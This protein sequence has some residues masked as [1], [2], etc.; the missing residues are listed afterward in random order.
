[1][2]MGTRRIAALREAA[3]AKHRL[4]KHDGAKWG[5]PDLVGE[6]DGQPTPHTGD[7]HPQPADKTA[8]E[9]AEPPSR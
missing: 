5:G 4:D 3:M 6:L 1:M 9:E 2:N 7:Q 8:G